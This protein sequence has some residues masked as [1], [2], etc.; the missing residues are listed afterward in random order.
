MQQCDR[1]LKMSGGGV[2][3]ERFSA[4]DKEFSLHTS[5]FAFILVRRASCLLSQLILM[6]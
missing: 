1:F 4:D 6:F 2:E 3:L 5:K